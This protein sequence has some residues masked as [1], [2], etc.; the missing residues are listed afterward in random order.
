MIHIVVALPAE[1]KPLVDHFDLQRWQAHTAC[2]LYHGDNM[3]LVVT[4]VG[5]AAAAAG[6]TFL[7][8]VFGPDREVAWLNAGVAGHSVHPLGSGF[9]AHT[10]TDDSNGQRY[11]PPH[12]LPFATPRE[13]LITVDTPPAEYP[14][15]ALVDMEASGFY[16]TASSLTTSELVQCFKVVSDNKESPANNV[17]ANRI[18]ALI[19]SH[20]KTIQ[21]IVTTLDHF[22]T[23]LQTL[24]KAPQELELFQRRWRF[25]VSEKHQLRK[26][27]RRWQVLAPKR[28]AWSRDMDALHKAEDVLKLLRVSVEAQLIQFDTLRRD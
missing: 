28:S 18:T 6:V 15:A 7:H 20:L 22:S 10:I 1:A 11:F 19:G 5:K 27:L 16:A 17:S 23:H 25:T 2:P 13:S 14:D 26:L 24:R 3:A 12:V 4:G 9:L 8:N 21:E